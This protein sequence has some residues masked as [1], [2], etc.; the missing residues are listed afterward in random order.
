MIARALGWL[1][2]A[3]GVLFLIKPQILRNRLQRKTIRRFRKVLFL[4]A[5]ALGVYLIG[6]AWKLEGIVA[7]II[8]L[9]GIIAIFKGFLLLKAKAMDKIMD[10]LAQQP[11]IFFRVSALIYIGIG[12]IVLL[13]LSKDTR[14]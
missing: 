12:I 5:I 1:W 4:I 9:L 2:I 14:I 7:K 8:V 11:L 13:G 6:A 10:W 3:M